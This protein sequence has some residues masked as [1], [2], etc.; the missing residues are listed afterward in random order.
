MIAVFFAAG[1]VENDS[2]LAL[3][4]CNIL[5]AGDEGLLMAMLEG[6]GKGAAGLSLPGSGLSRPPGGAHMEVPGFMSLTNVEAGNQNA[7]S[8][9]AHGDQAPSIPSGEPCRQYITAES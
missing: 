6:P 5:D 9:C 3:D 1:S 4:D 8:S 7:K 2:S